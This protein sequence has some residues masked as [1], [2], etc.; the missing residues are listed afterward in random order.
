MHQITVLAA[1]AAVLATGCAAS[2]ASRPYKGGTVDGIVYKLP[3]REYTVAV[4]YEL[5][6]CN[7]LDVIA[8]DIAVGSALVPSQDESEWF[9]IDPNELKKLG[10][11]VDPATI[12]LNG[13]MLS[14]I[15]INSTGSATQIVDLAKTA[16]K[17]FH[18]DATGS[19]CTKGAESAIADRVKADEL[20]KVRRGEVAAAEEQMLGTPTQDNERRVKLARERLAEAQSGLAKHR[21]TLLKKTVRYRF[22]PPSAA[23]CGDSQNCQDTSQCPKREELL[24]WFNNPDFAMSAFK[25]VLKVQGIDRGTRK[26]VSAPASGE[27]YSGIFYRRPAYA[28]VTIE[29]A[30]G[31]A[32]TAYRVMDARQAIPQLG[33]LQRVEMK[34][35]AFG[36]RN[37]S[38]TFDENG[39][40]KK[41]VFTSKGMA[42]ALTASLKGVGEAIEGE[43]DKTELEK[44]TE[45]VALLKKKKE[46]IDA[47]AELEA[48][49]ED[50]SSP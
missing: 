30:N 35:T 41:Y 26:A 43:P 2:I 45:E 13:G 48:A 29:V 34:G 8:T 50:G 20:I 4:T 12:E 17:M 18:L 47:K 37:V 9:V 38:V 15:G 36:S 46:L 14:I 1:F 42:E 7:T 22:M 23:A 33:I 27:F 11:S 39:E 44:L 31:P 40:I 32:N 5:R 3:V 28:T 19:V 10:S 25:V 6:A 24:D 49:T 16:I 21:D